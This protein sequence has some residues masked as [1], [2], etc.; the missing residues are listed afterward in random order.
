MFLSPP[1]HPKVFSQATRSTRSERLYTGGW[2]VF[3]FH[4]EA[5]AGDEDKGL[6]P[7]PVLTLPC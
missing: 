5:S 3:M 7:V 2:D 4:R 1:W 6:C